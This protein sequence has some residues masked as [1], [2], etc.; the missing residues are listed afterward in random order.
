MYFG[1][2]VTKGFVNHAVPIKQRLAL[3]SGGYHNHIKLGP[4]SVRE[5][6]HGLVS[7]F[8]P[9]VKVGWEF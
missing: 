1:H 4:T 5:V 3:K 2:V 7:E 9:W 6:P 8:P